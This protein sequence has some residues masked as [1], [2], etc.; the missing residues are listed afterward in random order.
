MPLF[1]SVML[2]LLIFHDFL[3]ELKVKLYTNTMAGTV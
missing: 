3:D 2:L 1:V